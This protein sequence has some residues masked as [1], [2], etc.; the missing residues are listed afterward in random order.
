MIV[1]LSPLLKRP[2]HFLLLHASDEAYAALVARSFLCEWLGVSSEKEH[3]PDLLIL[4]P[5][6]KAIVHTMEHIR[7]FLKEMSL[8]PFSGQKRGVLIRHIERML[9]YS[10]N[11]LLKTLEEPPLHTIIIGT[12]ERPFKLLPTIR[13]RAQEVGLSLPPE[14]QKMNRAVPQS[15]LDSLKTNWPFRSFTKILSTCSEIESLIQKS[16]SEVLKEEKEEDPTFRLHLEQEKTADCLHQIIEYLLK[17][18]LIPTHKKTTFLS[19]CQEVFSSLEKQT[20]VKDVL[21]LLL[22][23]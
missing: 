23:F 22:N 7:A 20:A 4:E 6:G 10:S 2:P 21:L 9:P 11:A 18:D 19:H 3:H 15:I 1:S 17:E 5:V 13:S 8:T 14:Y 12:T 16:L